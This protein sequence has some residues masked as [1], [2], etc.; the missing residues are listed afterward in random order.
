MLSARHLAD[1]YIVSYAKADEKNYFS[2][3][4]R[5]HKNTAKRKSG[6]PLLFYIIYIY[7]FL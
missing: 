6:A 7:N 5:F 1:T 3:R 2:H 4:K